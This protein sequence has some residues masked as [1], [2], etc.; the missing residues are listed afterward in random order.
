MNTNEKPGGIWS[1]AWPKPRAAVLRLLVIIIVLLPCDW[2]I[3]ALLV[4]DWKLNM[5]EGTE[6]SVRHLVEGSIIFVAA[7]SVV[8]LGSLLPAFGWLR[9]LFSWRTAH[10]AL[11]SLAVLGTLVGLFYAEEDFRGK[12]A[13]DAYRRE[14]E[15]RGE[16]LDFSAFIPKPVPDDQNFAATPVI[17]SWFH[18]QNWGR[19]NDDNYARAKEGMQ[20]NEDQRQLT[21]LVAWGRAF[22]ETNSIQKLK[23]GRLK[24]KK[25]EAGQL[26]LESRAKAAPVVLEALKT[27]DAVFTELRAASRRPH[28]RYPIDYDVQDP[29]EILLPH[30]NGVRGVCRRSSLKAC[31][32][33]AADRSEDALKDVE[34]ILYMANSLK[35]EP[36]IVSYLVRVACVQL[37]IQ[38][39]W[40]GLAEHA[41]SDTQLQELQTHLQ[42]YD[43][44]SDM[45]RPLDEERAMGIAVID[46]MRKKGRGPFVELVYSVSSNFTDRMLAYWLGGFV[47]RGWFYEEQLNYCK[48]YQVQWRGA[49]DRAT[50]RVSP[51]RNAANGRAFDRELPRSRSE[52]IMHHRILFPILLPA[53]GNFPRRGAIAQV[54]VDQAILAC[55]LERYRLANGQFP[56]NLDALVP[57]F[58][59][60]LV[61][62]V[63]TGEPYKYRRTD[64]GRFILYSVGWNE[65]DDGGVP[66]KTDFDDKEGDWVWQYPPAQ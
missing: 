39:I 54:A 46:F 20:V 24:I 19:W 62:D 3:F 48:A 65:K 26:D 57:V 60:Q 27:N 31:A 16:Q 53:L 33:L 59:S 10:R 15:A 34:L 47:P 40:E 17:Q 22:E 64:D 63:I 13:W 6:E 18:R 12:H 37:A 32:E 25:V 35:E 8:F 49:V 43:F 23:S 38:P 30:L 7:V 58:I 55:A 1:P 5:A 21:D 56:E 45:K 9:R 2:A 29:A 14:L 44:V 4:G 51:S 42:Q 50:K 52:A 61:H 41:W 66:G 11:I 36:F 28:S